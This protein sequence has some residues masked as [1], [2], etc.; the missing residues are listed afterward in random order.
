MEV[1][2]LLYQVPTGYD[3]STR[4]Y[5][6]YLNIRLFGTWYLYACIYRYKYLVLYD[7]SRVLGPLP[8]T[9]VAVAQFA[10]K[11]SHFLAYSVN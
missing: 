6:F 9:T 7:T 3:T 5:L 1:A 2:L 11:V 8:T 10:P 4:Y